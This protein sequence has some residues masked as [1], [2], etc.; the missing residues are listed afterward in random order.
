MGE[1]EIVELRE[2][3]LSG[4]ALAYQRLVEQKSRNDEELVFSQNGKIVKVK[5]RD[6][7]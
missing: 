5:A 3:I 7:K 2:K 4:I 6:L 1:K